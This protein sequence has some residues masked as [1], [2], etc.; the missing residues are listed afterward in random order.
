MASAILRKSLTELTRRRVRSLLAVTSLAVAVGSIGIFGLPALMDNAMRQEVAAG[1][2][3]D[4]TLWT[5]P[6]RLSAE[7]LAAL[8]ALPNV[9]AVQPRSYYDTRVYV[10]DRRE[11][12]VVIGVPDFSRQSVDVVHLESG[13]PPALGAV[14]TEEQNRKGGYDA[15]TGDVARIVGTKG[16]ERR[17]PIAGVGRNLDQA[18]EVI[19]EDRL[20]LYA[21]PETVSALSGERGFSSLHLRLDDRG[22]AAVRAT[23]GRVRAQLQTLVA[24]EPFTNLPE[25]RPPGDWPGK[26]ELSQFSSLLDIVTLLALLSAVVLVANTMTTLIG[27]QLAEIGT[28]KAIGGRRRQIAHIYLTTAL[29]LGLAGA[30]AG[31]V[32][33]VV[34]SNVLARFFGAEFFGIEP[35]L[36]VDMP[37]LL[38]SLAVGVL[39]PPLAAL[40]AVRRAT[41]LSVREAFEASQASLG[42]EG[43]VG[44]ALRRVRFVPRSAQ[45]GL[46]GVARSRRRAVATGLIVAV[47]VGNLLA[48]LAFATAVGDLTRAEWDKHRE[49][50]RLWTS[51]RDGFTGEAQRLIR[52]YPGVAEAQPVLVS[53][54]QVARNDAFVWA[55]PHEPLF[56]YTLSDG[57]WFTAQEERSRAR[58]AV[59]ESSVAREAG[60]SAGDSVVFD[61]ATGKARFRVVGVSSNQ[62]ENGF[63]AFAPLTTVRSILRSPRR[64]DSFWIK[65]TSSDHAFVDRTTTG[66]EDALIARGYEPGSE[67]TYVARDDNIARN[68]TLS[69]TVAV[70]GFV[71]VAISLVGLVNAIT[72]SVLERT[73][74]IGILRSIGA[75]GRD[76]R[77]IFSAEGVTLALF[78]WLLGIPLGYALMRALVWLTGESLAVNLEVV[79]PVRNIVIVLLGTVVLALVIL[80][81]PIRRAVRLR[82]GDAL[83]YG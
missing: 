19:F 42:A 74:E 83:R 28:M 11:D 62:Q 67:I 65:T 47:A 6:I 55:V 81:L 16:S 80:R 7:D 21:T 25:V 77:G 37:I 5:R 66:L 1:R 59:L 56:D 24:G 69:T 75:R 14:L 46:R 38:A 64:V 26:A 22:D 61:T 58:V 76:V 2:L 12:V 57:R 70:L 43:V 52:S 48:V 39:M 82:P 9:R 23:I 44:R 15:G 27:E 41:R 13:S 17:L 79:Y 35:P 36:A 60:V 4:V 51:G 34:L 53:D 49:D 8:R 54:V 78:G 32:V 10:G 31:A 45:I 71:V 20:V 3:A 33:G 63:V 72:M 29:L 50:I 30:V 18:Q 40:P 73:R 68:E